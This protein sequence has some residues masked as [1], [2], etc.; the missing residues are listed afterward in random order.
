MPVFL[1]EAELR[2]DG[3]AMDTEAVEAFPSP[4]SQLHVLLTTM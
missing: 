4:S 1:I 3:G 2:L